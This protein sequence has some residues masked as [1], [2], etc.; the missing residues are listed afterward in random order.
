MYHF[1]RQQ[2]SY[3]FMLEELKR[4]GEEVKRFAALGPLQA[5]IVDNSLRQIHQMITSP[6]EV[7]TMT[8]PQVEE[9]SKLPPQIRQ[10]SGTHMVGFPPA[11][12][13]QPYQSGYNQSI[14]GPR[15]MNPM[16]MAMA[17][18]IPFMNHGHP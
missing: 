2:R 12:H 17:Q 7:I 6:E 3:S 11:I 14:I 13:P 4:L 1:F 16:A 9:M 5:E 15:S 18:N 8:P 10:T